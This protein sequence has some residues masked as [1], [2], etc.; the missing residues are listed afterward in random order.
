MSNGGPQYFCKYS[1]LKAFQSNA[2]QVWP[3][4]YLLTYLLSL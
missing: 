2:S 1:M 4:T 3:F